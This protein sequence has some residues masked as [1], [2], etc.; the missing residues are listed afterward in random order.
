M[1]ALMITKPDFHWAAPDELM[2][3]II[4]GLLYGLVTD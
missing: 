1:V 2:H 3:V 4:D